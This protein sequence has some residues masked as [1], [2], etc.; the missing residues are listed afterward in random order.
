MTCHDAVQGGISDL[1]T[2]P[3]SSGPFRADVRNGRGERIRPLA[4]DGRHRRGRRAGHR[5]PRA[6]PLPARCWKMCP[7]PGPGGAHHRPTKI[8]SLKNSTT[9]PPTS[10]T[11][12]AKPIPTSSSGAPPT[13]MPGT[14]S[15]SPSSLRASKATP[16]RRS[17]RAQ[18]NM[19]TVRPQQRPAQ[20]PQQPSHSGLNYQKQALAEEHA[21]PVMRILAVGNFS[22]EERIVPTFA[23]IASLSNGRRS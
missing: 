17:C 13:R 5:S 14:R 3:A 15:A 16:R 21:M 23:G 10:M 9:R 8:C 22:D 6:R 12:S 1:I 2:V 20:Q 18:A 7:L 19:A 11:R 4:A